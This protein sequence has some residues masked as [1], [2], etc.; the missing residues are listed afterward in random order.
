M[1]RGFSL[2]ELILGLALLG[3]LCAVAIPRLGDQLDRLAVRRAVGEAWS[4]YQAARF[5]ALVRGSAVR[6]HFRP[7]S[8]IA[9]YELARDSVFLSRPGPGQDRVEMLG[10][11]LVT[12]LHANGLGAGA[13]NLT[14]TFR[15][16][17]YQEK[18]TLSRLGRLR[19]WR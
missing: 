19:R 14:L 13:A 2:I 3:I 7:D 4:F 18:L 17:R 12:R 1:R 10:S 8:L 11:K 16:G 6:L 15:R 5:S 9:A